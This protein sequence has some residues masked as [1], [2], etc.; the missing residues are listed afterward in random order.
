MH[1]RPLL[2]L[3]VLGASAL[4]LTACGGAEREPA[5]TVAAGDPEASSTPPAPVCAPLVSGCGCAYQ[6]AL[7]RPRPDGRYDVTH[8]LQDSR[9]DEAALVRRCFDAAGRAHPEAGATRC[10]DVF[11]D[12]TPC[13]GE[14]IPSLAYLDCV[15]SGDRCAF[16]GEPAGGEAR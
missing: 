8:D 1:A 5:A 15:L 2:A 12:L 16:R 4:L 13:G 9:T 6:C 3:W 11:D 14:C 7:G 10:V